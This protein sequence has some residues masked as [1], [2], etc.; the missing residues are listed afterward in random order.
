MLSL[1]AAA[2]ILGCSVV[3]DGTVVFDRVSSDSRD[4]RAGDLFVALRGERFDGHGFIA[5]AAQAGAVAV[6]AE[7][8]PEGFSGNALVVPDTRVALGLL[9]EGWRRRFAL[10]VIGV[11][12]SNGKTTVK[13]MLAAILAAAV[14]ET[15]RLATAGNLNNDIGTPL[16]T[17][18]LH[19]GHQ[20]AVIEMGMNHPGEIAQL[21][22]I[23]QP[24]VALVNNA[25]RE[26]Q[27]FMQSVAAVAQ[28]NGSVFAALPADGVAVFPAGTEFDALW[29]DLAGPR[30]CRS[31]ALD[32]G[33]VPGADGAGAESAG[34][35]DGAGAGA[36][37][38]AAAS[39]AADVI[40]H[41]TPTA[42]GWSLSLTGAVEVAGI[43]LHLFGRHNALNAVAAAASA[44]A[45]GVGA[46]AIR[47]GLSAFRPVKGRLQAKVAALAPATGARVLDDTYNANPDSVL[48]AIDVLAALPAPRVLVLGDMGEVGDNGPQFHAEVGA[49]ARERGIDTLVTMG[50]LAREALAAFANPGT[51]A[52]RHPQPPAES[53]EQAAQAAAFAAGSGG[54][55]LVKGSRFM[56]MERV[57]AALCGEAATGAH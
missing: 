9:A 42:T 52:P 45:A 13:E 48:A 2:A 41:A 6:L 57:V 19:S 29:R 44:A 32:D 53:A 18:R 17:L 47:A 16:T 24:T 12:G 20:L 3:G 46:E 26:H 5:G 7:S 25:Q 35:A 43:D 38:A 33:F 49:A 23:A 31:F 15:A 54:S 11:T 1:R 10:P 50:E 21:A 28:E 40:G 51:P 55:I 14:G 30:A 22:R 39:A 34:R 36:S 56:R 8:L 37:A 27:E 4:L